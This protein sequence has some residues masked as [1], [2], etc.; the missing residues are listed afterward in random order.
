MQKNTFFKKGVDFYYKKRYKW[1]EKGRKMIQELE[2]VKLYKKGGLPSTFKAIPSRQIIGQE[3]ALNAL[4]FA[5][6]LSAENAHLVCLGPKG[7]AT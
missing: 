7:E 1:P 5:V 3:R 6:N 4:N 2:E